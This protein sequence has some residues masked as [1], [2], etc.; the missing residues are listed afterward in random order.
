MPAAVLAPLAVLASLITPPLAPP[1]QQL[2]SWRQFQFERRDL[3]ALAAA[4][5]LRSR[6]AAAEDAP[7]AVAY[8]SAGDTRLLQPAIDAIK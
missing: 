8:L 6:P 5:M 4:A 7:L 2:S 3:A 1:K